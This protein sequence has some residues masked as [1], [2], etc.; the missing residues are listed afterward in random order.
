MP[1]SAQIKPLGAIAQAI[2][3]LT[4][5]LYNPP[6]TRISNISDSAWPNPLQPVQ[7]IGP[8]GS[9]PLSWAFWQ[10]QNLT[11]TPRATLQYSAVQLRALSMYPLARACIQN[12][13]D[14]VC[15]MPWR[16]QLIRMPGESE[17]DHKKRGEGDDQIGA[18][19]AFLQ[20]PNPQQNWKQLL[21]R[22]LEDLLVID[23]PAMLVRRLGNGKVAELRWT[24][25]ADIVQYIDELGYTP[26]GMTD[27]KPDVAYAQNWQ[28]MPRV[29]L[30][31]N[32]LVYRPYNLIP[33]GE[34][35]SSSQLYGTSP[36]EMAAAEI[37]IGINRLRFVGDWYTE[38]TTAD[39][40]Q[41][42]PPGVTPGKIAE[43]EQF[44]NSEMAGNSAQRRKLRLL[45][46]FAQDGKDQILFPKAGSL[47]DPYDDLHIR[48]ICFHYGVSAQRLLH[49][50]N[51]ATAEASQ[52]AAEEEGSLPWI[53]W[54]EDTFNFT[55]QTMM[56][57]TGYEITLD[58]TRQNDEQKEAATAKIYVDSGIK[59]RN[60]VREEIGDDPST[61]PE[62]D[63]LTVTTPNGVIP[64]DLSVQLA[65]ANV[66][67]AE[68]PPKPVIAAPGAQPKPAAGKPTQKSQVLK[69]SY[70]S[71]QVNIA[72]DSDAAAIHSGLIGQID[73]GH[74]AGNGAEYE[75]HI[76]V[77][78]GITDDEFDGIREYL[79]GQKP[80]TVT[81]GK[82]K[83]FPA[84]EHSDG[85][86]PIFVEVE[87]PDLV[88]INKELASHGNFKAADFT[89]TP[90]MTVAYVSEEYAGLYTD[91]TDL[92]GVEHLVSSIAIS[93]KNGPQ[94]S[95]RFGKART[96][97]AQKALQI[98][99][100]ESLLAAVERSRFEKALRDFFQ[101]E[102]VAAS[103]RVEALLGKTKKADNP[104]A[105]PD[106]ILAAAYDL[107]AWQELIDPTEKTLF[108]AGIAGHS[109]G[110]SQIPSVKIQVNLV[111]AQQLAQS[112]AH[113]R[114]AE[115]VGMRYGTDG[116]LR[117][118]P[119][120]K[121]AITETTRE[122]L[123]ADI[124][125]SFA[126][127]TR[128]SDLVAAIRESSAFSDSRAEMIANTEVAT[129]QSA[130]SYDAWKATG[131]VQTTR[132][133]LS[134][135]H[136]DID[137]CDDNA[138]AGEVAFGKQFPSGDL[139]TPA[140]PRCTCVNIV[141]TI[142]K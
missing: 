58:P 31:W 8:K 132:W 98:E 130:G 124:E 1:N 129:A 62:A 66:K 22:L 45:Q 55:I 67:T 128:I 86:S 106:A 137:E 96:I 33:R 134:A 71:T 133:V 59:T 111:E 15:G 3:Q 53:G 118:N 141:G 75:P 37:K 77:R 78:Y 131:L 29:D 74:L 105:D 108:S 2:T 11:Y 25:G 41:V 20:H 99:T 68:N 51:R 39:M 92:E 123:R 110:I 35:S 97:R 117:Q 42:V 101:K 52:G 10:G 47:T 70:G 17:R 32:Q 65:A 136:P 135:N 125:R 107:I 79:A 12:I 21:R 83:S 126:A 95:V 28:G 63:L 112:Y 80:F 88:R 19:T 64:L 7:P 48:K 114:A 6:S 13:K 57:F 56:G 4:G 27:G 90:H 5:R 102:A 60:E 76:T 50:Q 82:T 138:A 139:R 85:A 115:M 109:I 100:H 43:A 34:D 72:L 30:A 61:Q 54:V 14:Q 26:M 40:I 36:T 69:H 93:P 116:T 73:A 23:A 87:S 81:F 84:T 142:K 127:E 9:E 103:A 16:I 140:H 38:G 44:Q 18:I 119:N 91:L 24:D 46:G 122:T 121:W 104:P 113:T 94:E 120:A 49:M 89:Y